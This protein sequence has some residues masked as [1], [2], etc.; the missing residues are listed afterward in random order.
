MEC[1]CVLVRDVLCSAEQGLI[2]YV[3]SVIATT[4]AATFLR[5]KVAKGDFRIH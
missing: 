2:S 4:T 5:I 3:T 1:V